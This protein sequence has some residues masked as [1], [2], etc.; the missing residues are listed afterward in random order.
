MKSW[1]APKTEISELY[2]SSECWVEISSTGQG[3]LDGNNFHPVSF[4]CS[5]HC[6]FVYMFISKAVVVVQTYL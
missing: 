5:T 3:V 2:F 6:K 1:H 4:R